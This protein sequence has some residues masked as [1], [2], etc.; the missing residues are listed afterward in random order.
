MNISDTIKGVDENI[1][2][3]IKGVS[4]IAMEGVAME[5]V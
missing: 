5:G 3:T 4:E 1:D 2:D